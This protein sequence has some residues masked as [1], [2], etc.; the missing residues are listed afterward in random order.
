MHL[1]KETAS[2]SAAMDCPVK[3]QHCQLHDVGCASLNR[4][5]HGDSLSGLLHRLVPVADVGKVATPSEEGLD[6][7]VLFRVCHRLITEAS[8]L[9]VGG[10]VGVD[11]PDGFLPGDLLFEGEEKRT[12]PVHDAEIDGLGNPPLL[13]RDLLG[14]HT[15][16]Q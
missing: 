6:V 14:G 1:E 11:E 9:K 4:S 8:D 12:H 13:R 15:E 2:E 5:V 7:P 16:D 3:I 10:E